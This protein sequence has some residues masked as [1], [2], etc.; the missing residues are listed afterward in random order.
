MAD[1]IPAV[2]RKISTLVDGTLR[3]TVDI[4]PMYAQDAFALFGGG[5]IPMALAALNAGT[6]I[7][8]EPETA[9]EE[10]KGGELSRCAG[11]MVR[12][13]AYWESQGVGSMS[14]ADQIL[15]G[16]CRI[17]SKRELDHNPEAAELFHKHVRKP[18]LAWQESR[19]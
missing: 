11:M 6:Q 4:E 3:L 2:S 12:N 1:A 13:P 15:K 16:W 9:K 19:K 18:F 17:K 10:L 7:P 14:E 5:N 8:A